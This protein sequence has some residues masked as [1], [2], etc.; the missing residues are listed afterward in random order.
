MA[1]RCDKTTGLYTSWV[2]MHVPRTCNQQQQQGTFQ[3]LPL[4]H[5]AAASKSAGL[6]TGR[7][8]VWLLMRSS[9]LTSP[10]SKVPLICLHTT[11]TSL[12]AWEWRPMTKQG[13]RFSHGVPVSSCSASTQAL[14]CNAKH[15]RP[16][17]L[18]MQIQGLKWQS[19]TRSRMRSVCG[20]PD[21]PCKA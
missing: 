12:G 11:A 19:M 8:S 4:L 13:I 6:R 21:S 18:D 1:Y 10:S 2:D 3:F 5:P 16:M 20:V 17:H 15:C 14:V 7:P 9:C